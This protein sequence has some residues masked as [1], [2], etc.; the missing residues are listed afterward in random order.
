MSDKKD[1]SEYIIINTE[2]YRF[3]IEV[4]N[5]I[6]NNKIISKNFLNVDLTKNTLF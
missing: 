4:T 6:M 1:G 3:N 2:H 5:N